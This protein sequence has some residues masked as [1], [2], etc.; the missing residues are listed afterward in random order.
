MPRTSSDSIDHEIFLYGCDMVT[1]PHEILLR[2]TASS[3]HLPFTCHLPFTVTFMSFQPSQRWL[4]KRN[5]SQSSAAL[6]WFLAQ[7]FCP[8]NVWR[9]MWFLWLNGGWVKSPPWAWSLYSSCQSPTS[10]VYEIAKWGMGY[11]YQATKGSDGFYE[12]F[13]EGEAQ[14]K[15]WG[16]LRPS[17]GWLIRITFYWVLKCCSESTEVKGVE[18]QSVWHDRV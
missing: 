15:S 16:K 17:Q 10:L 14:G 6:L 5:L 2:D 7:L 4:G 3:G 8:R 13:H 18:F 9:E 1:G 12:G 11:S